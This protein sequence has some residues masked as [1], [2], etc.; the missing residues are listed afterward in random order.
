MYPRTCGFVCFVMAMLFA[1]HL[2]GATILNPGGVETVLRAAARDTTGVGAIPTP[3]STRMPTAL[4]Y[5]DV[6]SITH[7][8]ANS[9]NTYRLS[10]TGFTMGMTHARPGPVDSA[11]NSH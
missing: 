2:W 4:P 1:G 3:T 6:N 10:D 11:A 8:A 7:G 9:S 5:N